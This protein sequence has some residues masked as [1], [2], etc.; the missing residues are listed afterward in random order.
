MAE[1]T[2][3]TETTDTREDTRT[4]IATEIE[5]LRAQ[6]LG[7][8]TRRLDDLEQLCAEVL[9]LS[10]GWSQGFESLSKEIASLWEQ[11]E[12]TRTRDPAMFSD[13]RAHFTEQVLV[14][15]TRPQRFDKEGAYDKEG[16]SVPI[17]K[18]EAE[19]IIKRPCF[20]CRHATGAII[21]KGVN[22]GCR[23]LQDDM[24]L[25]KQA[26]LVRVPGSGVGVSR[27]GGIPAVEFCPH[28]Q[29]LYERDSQETAEGQDAPADS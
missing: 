25:T 9:K 23:K 1:T 18:D 20:S 12:S 19:R 7:G 29:P 27:A 26:G 4:E 24:L 11:I 2:E 6:R 21:G 15:L 14:A 13:V 17:K 22:M 3:T 28:W 16:D 5:T 10:D 8:L